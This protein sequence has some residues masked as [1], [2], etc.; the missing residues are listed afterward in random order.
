M[1]D[2]LSN[3]VGKYEYGDKHAPGQVQPANLN[4]PFFY[5]V[6]QNKPVGKIRYAK[7]SY[8]DEQQIDISKPA[9]QEGKEGD[10]DKNNKYHTG[11]PESIRLVRSLGDAF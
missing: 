8:Y 4:S 1:A 5:R 9:H 3:E 11:Q 2:F 7:I 6:A 10:Y